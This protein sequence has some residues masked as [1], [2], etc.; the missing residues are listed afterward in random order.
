M[1][2]DQQSDLVSSLLQTIG[3]LEEKLKA[4][5]TAIAE[6]EVKAA[7]FAEEL[8]GELHN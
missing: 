6:A 8:A 2:E 3:D 4:R 5:D 1:D 7:N